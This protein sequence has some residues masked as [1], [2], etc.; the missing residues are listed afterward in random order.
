MKE[1]TL[2]KVWLQIEIVAAFI[3]PIYY[4]IVAVLLI[5]KNSQIIEKFKYVLTAVQEIG[6]STREDNA[7]VKIVEFDDDD[8]ADEDETPKPF[9]KFK[10]KAKR[11]AGTKKRNVS[12]RVEDYDDKEEEKAPQIVQ[13]N[14]SLMIN[15]NE[16]LV[17][18]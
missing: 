3:E 8:E 9:S 10:T 2:S 1:N 4:E 7:E 11:R 15:Y 12:F 6:V 18:R 17:E 13:D 5:M 14:K 16:N